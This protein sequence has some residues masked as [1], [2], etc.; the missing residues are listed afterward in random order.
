MT[1]EDVPASSENVINRLTRSVSLESYTELLIST[2]LYEHTSAGTENTESGSHTTTQTP[3]IPTTTGTV[4]LPHTP[5]LDTLTRRTSSSHH[6]R[7]TQ[8]IDPT[9]ETPTFTDFKSSIPASRRDK[10]KSH[11]RTTSLTSD[12][13]TYAGTETPVSYAFL[14]TSQPGTT[15]SVHTLSPQMPAL[16]SDASLPSVSK[17]PTSTPH[18]DKSTPITTTSTSPSSGDGKDTSNPE[19]S[20]QMDDLTLL[21]PT[22]V[23]ST[24]R[25][26]DSTVPVDF[27]VRSLQTGNEE[28]VINERDTGREGVAESSGGTADNGSQDEVPAHDQEAISR[29]S[30]DLPPSGPSQSMREAIARLRA[31]PPPKSL[32]EVRRERQEQRDQARTTR[33]TLLS[34]LAGRCSSVGTSTSTSESLTEALSP[35]SSQHGTDALDLSLMDADLCRRLLVRRRARSAP[36]IPSRNQA[37]R[38]SARVHFEDDDKSEDDLEAPE[39]L[40]ETRGPGR[41][42]PSREPHAYTPWATN[43]MWRYLEPTE[44]LWTMGFPPEVATVLRPMPWR[45]ITGS[46]NP[47]GYRGHT[48][49]SAWMMER[50]SGTVVPTV[51]Y[52]P[53]NNRLLIHPH[54]VPWVDLRSSV[55]HP[56]HL[57]PLKLCEYQALEACNFAVWRHDRNTIRCA[58]PRCGKKL[59]DHDVTTEI[60]HGCG[61]QAGI[62][63]C[64]KAHLLADMEEHWKECGVSLIYPSRHFI[65][66]LLTLASYRTQQLACPSTW[67]PAPS[68]LGSRAATPPSETCGA[69]SPTPSTGS[70]H[71]PSSQRANTRSFS[72]G[73]ASLAPS[74]GAPPPSP[75]PT[76]LAWSAS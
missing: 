52:D 17:T 47:R 56:D 40:Q 66:T 8:T 53:A 9:S 16:T 14:D 72:R 24:S 55:S 37:D 43:L 69:K 58:L 65:A 74:N 73:P 68:P 50:G 63:Y 36:P 54:E 11:V 62:R 38:W 57:S 67:M 33:A 70:E 59:I 28:N 41:D 49:A 25:A 48:A 2:G 42:A 29:P 76:S 22:V 30:A 19:T 10:S 61:P 13:S 51:A 35:V 7:Y 3:N 27:N 32:E 20:G 26:A 31:H 39:V 12:I 64:S 60:C 46:S 5:N 4:T 44:D 23:A 45:P 1:P 34:R 21:T 75:P 6:P 18:L 15:D 71:T